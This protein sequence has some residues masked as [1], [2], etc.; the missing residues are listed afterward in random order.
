LG[1]IYIGQ[2]SP[3]ASPA[4]RPAPVL[5]HLPG[6]AGEMRI[7]HE[8]INGLTDAGV[9]HDCRILDWTGNDRGVPALTNVERHTEKS[10]KL[11]AY[12][13]NLAKQS[14]GMPIILTA[15]SAGTGDAVQA[16]EQLPDGETIQNLVLLASALSPDYDLSRALRHVAGHAYSLHSPYDNLVLSVGT[17]TFGTYDR[18]WTD[19]AGFCGFRQPPDADKAA[20]ARLTQLPYDPAW[21]K[22]GNG[23]DHIGP[24]NR[25]FARDV[26]GRLVLTGRLP[27]TQPAP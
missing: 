5:V 13:V 7:D 19:A 20:Y 10:A 18:V 27:T 26:L 1:S 22:I 17:R 12:I 3:A 11:A 16:L 4:T 24:T 6:I 21:A 23:G 9:S 15:H 14:P 25:R 8:L 2:A